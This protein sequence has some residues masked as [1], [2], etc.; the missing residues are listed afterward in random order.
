VKLRA[1]LPNCDALF[2]HQRVTLYRWH[3]HSV[4]FNSV[5]VHNDNNMFHIRLRRPNYI[6][7]FLLRYRYKCSIICKLTKHNL[8]I[9]SWIG[10]MKI[11]VTHYIARINNKMNII[12][13][14]FSH[15]FSAVWKLLVYLSIDSKTVDFTSLVT[16]IEFRENIEWGVFTF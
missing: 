12:L 14:Y 8:W 15:F 5:F 7:I 16:P 10:T 2:N 9:V 3:L 1:G 11:K 4:Q 13:L 6:F